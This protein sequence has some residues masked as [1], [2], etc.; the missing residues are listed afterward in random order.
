VTWLNSKEAKSLSLMNYKTASFFG[1]EVRARGGVS[2][3]VRRDYEPVSVES[4]EYRLE[5]ASVIFPFWR[6]EIPCFKSL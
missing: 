4:F 6:S 3:L 5:L 2:I 1:R